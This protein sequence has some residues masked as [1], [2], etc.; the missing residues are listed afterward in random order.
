MRLYE[1]VCIFNSDLG[2]DEIATKVEGFNKLLTQTKGAEVIVVEPWGTRQL[3]YPI[4]ARMQGYYMVSHVRAAAPDLV[5]FERALT[6][7]PD[8]LRY[9]IVVNEGEPATGKSIMSDRPVSVRDDDDEDDED[10]RDEP[11]AAPRVGEDGDSDAEPLPPGVAPP[12]F[13]GGRGRFRRTEGPSIEL[14]N[15][16]DVGTLS[17]FMTE[18]GKILPKRTTKVQAAFQRKLGSAIK[19]ARFLALIPYVRDHEA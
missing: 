17:R 6:L 19:R 2:E 12:E 11:E 15:Y 7:E 4:N 18:Q 10:D 16:K 13:A 9:L 3:A 1:V 5:E 8:V 14:L